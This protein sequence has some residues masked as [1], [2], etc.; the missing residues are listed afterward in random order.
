MPTASLDGHASVFEICEFV[1]R[2]I[3]MVM[4]SWLNKASVCR[5]SGV[6]AVALLQPAMSWNHGL[7]LGHLR[8]D[9]K[10]QFAVCVQCNEPATEQHL[11]S[12]AHLQAQATAQS[13][14]VSWNHGLQSGYLRWDAQQ[15]YVWCSLCH[16]W[17]TDQHLRNPEHLEKQA[18]YLSGSRWGR[19][20]V[21]SS[22]GTC[23]GSSRGWK[24]K[25]G[26]QPER[27]AGQGAVVLTA[28][29]GASEARTEGDSGAQAA[30]LD[31]QLTREERDEVR[32]LL[33]DEGYDHGWLEWVE[34]EKYPRCRLCGAWA[35]LCHLQGKKHQT[36]LRT[37]HG[38]EVGKGGVVGYG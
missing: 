31:A 2:L 37:F 3:R 6:M 35:T 17:A 12:V 20:T 10:R 25:R 1:A 14:E 33:W 28:A 15:G 11:R 38:G 30:V 34:Q 24:R 21:V 5:C 32:E 4:C 8:W 23:P 22:L 26:R 19:E 9:F 16:C 36:A 29:S 7:R 18:V 27:H 13:Q